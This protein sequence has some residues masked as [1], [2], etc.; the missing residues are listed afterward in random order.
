MPA[1]VLILVAGL[2]CTGKTWLARQLTTALGLPLVAKDDIKEHLF[3]SLGWSDRAWSKKLGLATFD[4]LFY[5]IELELAAGR[6]LI[7]EAN[8]YPQFH[9]EKFRALQERWPFRPLVVECVA[10]SEIL[11]QRFIRRSELGERH[12]G[13]VDH[14]NYAEAQALL[15]G[16]KLPAFRLGGKHIQVDM[17]D[18]SR[19]D[20]QALLAEIRPELE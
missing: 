14:K 3:D 16:E 6:S 5:I 15:F 9:I 8:F 18:F 20:L 10:D 19:F 17:N 11:F 4:L 7:A 2:P 1:P 13:H 12:P